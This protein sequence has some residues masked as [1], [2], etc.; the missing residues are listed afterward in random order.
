VVPKPVLRTSARQPPSGVLRP[1]SPA[2]ST[3]SAREKHVVAVRAVHV[4]PVGAFAKLDRL[5]EE[6]SR[7]AGK[8]RF[9]D[10]RGAAEEQQVTGDTRVGLCPDCEDKCLV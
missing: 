3:W 9:V 2:G 4:E 1:P 5:F 6:R 8:H 10:D 7:F